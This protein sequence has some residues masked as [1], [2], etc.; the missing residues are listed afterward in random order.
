MNHSIHSGMITNINSQPNVR[1]PKVFSWCSLR[2][3]G[4]EIA[5]NTHVKQGFFSILISPSRVFP[6][7]GPFGVHPC[8][9]DLWP[10]RNSP[11]VV[12][13][14]CWSERGISFLLLMVE[15]Y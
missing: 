3:L 15:S 14:F 12:G 9:P 13:D 6:T 8:L 5:L 7:L 1:V 2:I 4:D 10:E 11:Q